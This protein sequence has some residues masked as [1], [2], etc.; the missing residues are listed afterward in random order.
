MRKTFGMM[1]LVIGASAVA[2]ATAVPEI[3]PASASSALALITGG[4]LVIGARRK[5]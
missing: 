3:D 4:L 1:L 5:K 2:S